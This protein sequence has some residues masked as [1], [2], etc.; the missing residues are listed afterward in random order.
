MNQD[1]EQMNMRLR[2]MRSYNEIEED[3]KNNPP[4]KKQTK[5]TR[6]KYV[7]TVNFN[8]GRVGHVT[9][10]ISTDPDRINKI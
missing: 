7:G 8:D 3:L 1:Q 5:Q 6:I 2:L 9:V 4:R 10:M